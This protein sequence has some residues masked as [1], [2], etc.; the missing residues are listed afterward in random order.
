MNIM[1]DKNCP[2]HIPM[3]F[4]IQ[5]FIQSKIKSEEQYKGFKTDHVT[6]TINCMSGSFRNTQLL[7]Y[8][9]IY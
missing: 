7:V 6:A 2:V 4:I 5:C 8:S 9:S 3:E 1:M